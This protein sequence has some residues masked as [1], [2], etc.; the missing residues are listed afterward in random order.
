MTAMP[1]QATAL[2]RLADNFAPIPMSVSLGHGGSAPLSPKRRPAQRAS[3]TAITSGKGGVGK[4]NIAVNLA[5]KFAQSGKRVLLIDADLGLA[6]ADVLSGIEVPYN[7]SHVLAGRKTV[8]EVLVKAPGGFDLLGGASGL[9]RMADLDDA[10]RQK[11]L[12]VIQELERGADIILIDT[13]AGISSNVLAFCRAAD[14]VLVVTT[15]EPTA[16]TD[17]YALVKSI[18]ASPDRKLSLLVNQAS[19]AAEAQAVYDRIAKV[20][21]Q[22]LS[23]NVLDAGHVLRD[24]EVARS[25]RRRTPLLLSAP[26]AVAARSISQLAFRLEP[27]LRPDNA[28][29]FLGKWFN[30]RKGAR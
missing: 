14:H 29:G 4:S 5:V 13:G 17:A 6:N 27:G 1:D 24:E 7:L 2:R 15:P 22:F 30:R 23:A 18:G 21:R 16:V 28:P 12:G 9:S 20:A 25:V 26:N 11:L 19:G 8:R 10:G 3:V